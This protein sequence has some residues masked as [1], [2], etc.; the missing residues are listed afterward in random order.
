MT[1]KTLRYCVGGRWAGNAEH[2]DPC[3]TRFQHLAECDEMRT[4]GRIALAPAGAT[5]DVLDPGQKLALNCRGCLP[6]EAESGWLCEHCH[7]YLDQWLADGKEN[8]LLYAWR[9]LRTRYA[10]V[11]SSSA[12]QDWERSGTREDLPSALREAVLDCRRLMEDRVF[13]GEERAR[14]VLTLPAEKPIADLPPFS[15]AEGVAFL[16]NHLLRIE[17]NRDLVAWLFV[18]VQDSM[19]DAHRLAPWRA[20]ATKVRGADGPIPCPHCERKTLMMYGGDS[21]VTCASCHMTIHRERFDQWSA[22]I[23]SEREEA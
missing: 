13:I 10:P 12:H 14:Q 17:D 8:S 2:T 15:M 9:Y 22:M 4:A 1:V 11:Q 16:R 21:F 3:T 23:E 18:R 20:T 6:R 7:R 5:Q 19:V